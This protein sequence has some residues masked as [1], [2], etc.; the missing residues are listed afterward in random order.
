MRNTTWMAAAMTAIAL[1]LL[2]ACKKAEQPAEPELSTAPQDTIGEPA[3]AVRETPTQQPSR[4]DIY[5]TVRLSAPV[6]SGREPEGGG[7]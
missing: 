3:V 5:A 1:L 4:F 6:G 2:A 7:C